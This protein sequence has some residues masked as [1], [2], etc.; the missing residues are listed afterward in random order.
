MNG[1]PSPCGCALLAPTPCAS[2]WNDLNT[3]QD[4]LKLYCSRSP[5]SF[6]PPPPPPAKPTLLQYYCTTIAQYTPPP[7]T[8][9]FNAMHH[10]ISVMAISCKGQIGA[11]FMHIYMYMSITLNIM[12]PTIP[13]W[14]GN[15]TEFSDGKNNLLNVCIL[16]KPTR[17]AAP[18][19]RASL[20][21]TVY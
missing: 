19:P 1:Y 6:H 4:T 18:S 10:I 13:L 2:D 20:G 5:S 17:V 15:R 21:L 9:P 7:P 16:T 12:S 3:L 14:N 11:R 8:L